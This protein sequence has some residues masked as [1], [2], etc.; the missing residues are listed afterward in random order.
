MVSFDNDWTIF[1]RRP[2]SATVLALAI[3]GLLWPVAR[4]ALAHYR[5]KESARG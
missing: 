4:G 1:F 2:I 3:A 5:R